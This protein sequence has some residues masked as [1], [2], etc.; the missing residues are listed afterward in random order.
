MFKNLFTLGCL[1]K[2]K[3]QDILFYPTLW[4]DNTILVEAWKRYTS[5]KYNFVFEDAG[6]ITS[7][8]MSDL[9]K[10]KRLK[11]LGILSK[12]K[13]N[14]KKVYNEEEGRYF[15]E[16]TNKVLVEDRSEELKK[17]LDKLKF[18]GKSMTYS[19]F[20]F[21]VNKYWEIFKK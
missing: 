6:L 3:H 9:I 7:E 11:K 8:E 21:L 17:Y 10:N 2:D 19:K 20:C 15:G 5:P 16:N 18:Q 1:Y 4:D 14:F 13:Y 12:T